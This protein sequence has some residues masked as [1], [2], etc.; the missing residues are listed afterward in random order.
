MGY[1]GRRRSHISCNCRGGSHSDIS[2]EDVRDNNSGG[3]TSC[4]VGTGSPE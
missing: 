3:G 2:G 1:H 4:A